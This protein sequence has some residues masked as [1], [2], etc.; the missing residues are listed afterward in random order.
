M[1]SS[2]YNYYCKIVIIMIGNTGVSRTW[3]EELL[4]GPPTNT[5]YKNMFL[6]GSPSDRMGGGGWAA[7]TCPIGPMVNPPLSFAALYNWRIESL[8]FVQSFLRQS[9]MISVR[10]TG[11]CQTIINVTIHYIQKFTTSSKSELLMNTLH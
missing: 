2:I 1:Q 5:L 3:W 8:L 6:P 7:G 11:V 9:F 4:L 10:H